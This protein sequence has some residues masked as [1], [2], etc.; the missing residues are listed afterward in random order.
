MIVSDTQN[1]WH[2][3]SE[4]NKNEK[5][6]RQKVNERNKESNKRKK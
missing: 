5:D 2:K 6:I 4:V 1:G 3:K